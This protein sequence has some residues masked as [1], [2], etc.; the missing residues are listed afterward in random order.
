MVKYLQRFS[1]PFCIL[2]VIGC[3][4]VPITE[5]RQ[6]T[7]IPSNEMMNL[8][9]QQYKT[10]LDE[11]NLSNNTQKIE[12]LRK[13]GRK[14]AHA[15]DDFYREKGLI[16]DFEWEY[17]L[18][19]DD[20]VVNAW[21][22]P[23]GKIAFYTGILKYTQDETGMAAV[24]GHE[25]AHAIAKHG[26]ERMSQS[27]LAQIGNVALST[28][29]RDKPQLT[30]QLYMT[31]FGLGAQIGILLPYSRLQESEADR[32]GLILM[33]KAGYD[34]KGAIHFWERMRQSK[35]GAPPEFLSTHPSD[36]RRINDLE[37]HLPEALTHHS[38]VNSPHSQQQ[39]E[40]SRPKI[41]WR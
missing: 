9:R 36:T 21:C 11:S 12:Q 1:I 39:S 38:G 20:D 7:I 30:Q 25:V 17:H 32:I 27:M 24:M 2:L 34:P 19:E 16:N 3:A 8:S 6:F 4:T 40:P 10:V 14:I 15:V 18:I 13:V 37:R 35:S 26:N 29:I 23:G 22:M 31:A 28:A 33:A 5:R 41:N